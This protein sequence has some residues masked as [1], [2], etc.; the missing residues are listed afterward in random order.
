MPYTLSM[1]Q[2]GHIIANNGLHERNIVWQGLATTL[3]EI[4]LKV[5]LN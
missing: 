5:R 1:Q 4:P 3:R 2:E